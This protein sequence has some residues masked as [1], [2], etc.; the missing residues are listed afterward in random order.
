MSHRGPGFAGL[1]G[2][3][4]PTDNSG[5]EGERL[6][7]R[8]VSNPRVQLQSSS[9]AFESIDPTRKM[10]SA[11]TPRSQSTGTLSSSGPE[12][13]IQRHGERSSECVKE[14]VPLDMSSKGHTPFFSF[15]HVETVHGDATAPPRTRASPPCSRR[16][17]RSRSQRAWPRTCADP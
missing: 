12:I 5:A 8:T 6:D 10:A 2:G 11:L 14:S 3:V 13:Y 4:A 1:G 15:P 7:G 9:R 16:S 17:P